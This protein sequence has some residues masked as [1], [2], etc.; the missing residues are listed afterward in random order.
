MTYF[1]GEGRK[2]K[3]EKKGKKKTRRSETRKER[4]TYTEFLD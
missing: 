3:G 1:R 4:K 2:K